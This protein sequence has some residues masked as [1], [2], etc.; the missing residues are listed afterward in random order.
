M[1]FENSTRRHFWFQLGISID[2]LEPVFNAS[3]PNASAPAY[4]RGL[5]MNFLPPLLTQIAMAAI[6][7]ITSVDTYRTPQFHIPE[8]VTFIVRT[9]KTFPKWGYL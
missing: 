9:V 6:P 8:Q 1:I 2:I 7:S 3:F 5:Q 4:K